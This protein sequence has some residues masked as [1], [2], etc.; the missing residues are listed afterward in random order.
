MP[1]SG[2]LLYVYYTL[3]TGK[4]IVGI[5]RSSR[6]ECGNWERGRAVSFLEIFFL[7]FLVKCLC[8]VGTPKGPTLPT[9]ETSPFLVCR[10]WPIRIITLMFT[11]LKPNRERT[12]LLSFL[13]HNL[14]STQT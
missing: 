9:S 12:I 1:F 6:H 13:W 10:L 8:S 5:Y 11:I 7:E 2:V 14:E 4:L 3:Y